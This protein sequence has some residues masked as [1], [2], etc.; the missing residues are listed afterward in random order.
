[1]KKTLPKLVLRSEAIRT[2]VPIE[3]ARAVG[4]VV[5][6]DDKSSCVVAVVP[7]PAVV[8]VTATCG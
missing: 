8:A 6:T 3:L 4:G 7:A 5:G 2:L 1:M